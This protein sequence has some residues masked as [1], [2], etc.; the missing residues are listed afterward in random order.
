MRAVGLLLAGIIPYVSGSN[1]FIVT[2][3]GNVGPYS[4]GELKELEMSG[5]VRSDSPLVR[6]NDGAGPIPLSRA[7]GGAGMDVSDD[8]VN[9]NYGHS[10][11]R[12]PGRSTAR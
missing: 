12:H 6:E 8:A 5:F 4:A 9:Q 11:A 7:I 10:D 3:E 1:W 2:S